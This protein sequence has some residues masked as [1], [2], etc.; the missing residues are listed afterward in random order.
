MKKSLF[1]FLALGVGRLFSQTD[2]APAPFNFNLGSSQ[3]FTSTSDWAV[4]IGSITSCT[5]TGSSGTFYYLGSNASPALTV[6]RL[7][8]PAV[9]TN[10]YVGISISW[11]EFRA[12]ASSPSITAEWSNDNGTTWNVIPHAT[13]AVGNWAAITP[14][15]LPSA[16]SGTIIVFRFS[17]VA[18][19]TGSGAHSVAIDDIKITGTPSPSYYYDGSGDL[20]DVT[21]WGQNTNGTGANPPDF[22]TASQ[23]F[24]IRNVASVTLVT[25]WTVSGSNTFLNVGDG[26]GNNSRLVIP[27]GFS[28]N[29]GNGAGTN[30]KLVVN[31]SSSLTVVNTA[32]PNANDVIL[33]TTSFVDFAQA[34]AVTIWGGVAFSYGNLTLSGG[35]SKNQSLN[36]TVN[37]S[38]TVAAGTT[39]SM[40]N[41]T[42]RNTTLNGSTSF[43]GTIT[44]GTSNLIIGGTGAIG[45]L[46]FTGSGGINNLTLNRGSQTLT[47]GSNITV[48]NITT[49]TNGA[50]ALSNRALTLNGDVTFPVSASNGA[51][52][53][54]ATSTLNI[55]GTG[56]FTNALLMNQ[57]TASTRSLN[58]FIMTRANSTLA[59]GSTSM[60]VNNFS[61]TNGFISFNDK[62]L[63]ING[64][65]TFPSSISNGGFIGSVGSVLIISGTSGAAINNS[66]FMDQTNA[67]TRTIGSFYT[68]RGNVTLVLGNDLIVAGTASLTLGIIDLNGQLLTLTGPV[69][70][71][72]G[73]SNRGFRG[74]LTSSLTVDNSPGGTVSGSLFM[75]Q[76]NSGTRS[77]SRL[78]FDRTGESLVIGNALETFGE[79]V[80]I[81]GTID[82]NSNLYIRSNATSKG[83]IAEVT[84][85]VIGDASV[86]TF[87]LGG[88]TDWANLG[89]SGING[90]Q[91]S[92]WEGQIPMTCLSCPNTPTATGGVYFVSIQGWDE[93]AANTTTLQYV[94]MSYGDALVPGKGYWTYLGN[95]TG[96]TSDI[97]WTVVGTVVQGD[98]DIP[99]TYSG[100]GNGDGFNFISNPYPSAISWDDIYADNLAA[101]PTLN[102]KLDDAIYVYSA[103]L[104]PTAYSSGLS[105]T[106]G[107]ITS[108]IPMGQGFYVQ[109]AT[110]V[111]LTIKENNKISSTA[112]LLKTTNNNVGSVVR[113]KVDGGGFTDY[114]AIRF[115]SDATAG[116]D[117]R[118]D[119]HKMYSA[120][121]YASGATVNRTAIATLSNNKDYAINSLPNATTTDAV[122]PVKVL[123]YATGQHTITAFDLQNLPN[124]CVILKDNLTN[125]THDLKASPYVCN[126][127]TTETTPR[128]ELK[129]CADIT[130]SVDESKFTD[131]NVLISQ[132]ANGVFVKLNYD[133]TVKTTISVTNI[134]GQQVIDSKSV[135]VD[136][137]VIYLNVPEKNQVLFVTVTSADNKVTKKIVR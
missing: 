63:T 106:P 53:G 57:T 130:M 97:T 3:S 82:A 16:A 21:N 107:G 42:N 27:A 26:A 126:I 72:S 70:F 35:G 19:G 38:L 6:E 11:N 46:S 33:G 96:T 105:D 39:Y 100:S 113:L 61:F 122:I 103:D 41:N 110:D 104:G 22:T 77:L 85:V 117:R 59:L 128:F 84:G 51:F 114:T 101:D 108:D 99:L 134:L 64:V 135:T 31:N 91:V 89:P 32:M 80:P 34:S 78:V 115:H 40:A 12:N 95:A 55:G 75:N 58:A 111:T 90:L 112:P 30:A 102:L 79:I 94:E 5:V 124:S 132:D 24:F 9:N 2:I 17:Y 14:T 120:P 123:A 71:A 62:S 66:L 137:D 87:A 48:N 20:A 50:L 118:L 74:S 73:S 29:I 121:G 68:T 15:V 49:L 65:I 69:S 116:F 47:L 98:Q 13:P 93:T 10:T 28:L 4:D 25:N 76:T 92:S 88:T 136:K 43:G 8:S 36:V 7:G 127:S 86:E 131:Q 60:A 18:T 56:A 83:R 109:A 45:T 129:V 23:N 1:L 44:Q 67:T 52:I 37:G 81:A 119:A 133:K 54:G 125:T